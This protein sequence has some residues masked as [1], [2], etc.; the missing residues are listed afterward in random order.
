MGKIKN[1]EWGV[2]GLLAGATIENG[3]CVYAYSPMLR[4]RLHNP[5]MYA[6]IRIKLQNQFESK[7]ALALCELCL[8]YLDVSRG[9]GETPWIEIETI[10]E[11]TGTKKTPTQ[12]SKTLTEEFSKNL[13][14]RSTK[15]QK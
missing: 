3:L 14:G 13:S 9:E 4:E 10:R 12:G 7:Y 15:F 8:D 11:L 5:N 6:K 1:G 2:S